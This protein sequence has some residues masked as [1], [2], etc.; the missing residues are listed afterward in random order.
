MVIGLI[1]IQ[2]TLA[3]RRWVKQ[4]DADG[5]LPDASEVRRV[6]R[7]VMIQAHIMVLIP[8]A[9]SLLARGIWTR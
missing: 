2:P 9:G 7:L 5:T 1:S 8:L 3:F 4:V 6:R